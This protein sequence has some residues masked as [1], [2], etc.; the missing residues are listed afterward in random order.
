MLVALFLP[1]HTSPLHEL[2]TKNTLPGSLHRYVDK[3]ITWSWPVAGVAYTK[4]V[5]FRPDNA[6][7][8]V[9]PTSQN[10]FL[11]SLLDKQKGGIDNER[12]RNVV[13]PQQARISTQHDVGVNYFWSSCTALGHH[14][15]LLLD[16]LPQVPTTSS[17][18][19]YSWDSET[20]V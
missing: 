14:Y 13:N 4:C 8:S 17:C 6:V 2:P 18:L 16:P 3:L 10:S 1:H 7:E 12:S 20:E 9:S 11:H 5:S 15:P 19:A